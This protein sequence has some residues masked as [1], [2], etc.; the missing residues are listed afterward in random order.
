MLHL[1]YLDYILV[2]YYYFLFPITFNSPF[3]NYGLGTLARAVNILAEVDLVLI[4]TSFL[5]S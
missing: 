3:Y 2:I 4:Q 1:D 5:F